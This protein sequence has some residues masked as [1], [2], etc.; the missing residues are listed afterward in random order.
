MGKNIEA[1]S[2]YYTVAALVSAALMP[3]LYDLGKKIMRNDKD[4]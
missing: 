1:D 4:K 2:S 3:T